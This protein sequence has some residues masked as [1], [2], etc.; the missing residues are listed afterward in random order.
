MSLFS[1]T[2]HTENNKF[3][4]IV[5][6][7]QAMKTCKHRWFLVGPPAGGLKRHGAP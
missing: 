5:G 7:A 2:E 6:S 3:E 4:G 1:I